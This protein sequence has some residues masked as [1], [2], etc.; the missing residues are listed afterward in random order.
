MG[1]RKALASVSVLNEYKNPY[2]RLQLILHWKQLFLV[3]EYEA[4]LLIKYYDNNQD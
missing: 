4:D 1:F 2:E 3:T